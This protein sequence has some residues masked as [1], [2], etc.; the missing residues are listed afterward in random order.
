[1]PALQVPVVFVLGARDHVTP[2]TLA[3]DYLAELAAPC[4]RLL[5]V[6]DAAHNVPFEQPDTFVSVLAGLA[7]RLKR[8]LPSGQVCHVPDLAQAGRT[9]EV[10]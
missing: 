3:V 4:K 5:V 7:D 9:S 1:M 10:D 8:R 6:D 2:T